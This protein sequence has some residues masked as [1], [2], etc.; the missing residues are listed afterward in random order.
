MAVQIEIWLIADMFNFIVGSPPVESSQI[1]LE[2]E[3]CSSSEPA[4]SPLVDATEW[5][6]L[7]ELVAHPLI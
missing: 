5:T 4:R 2:R 7:V 1:A 3:R 6:T